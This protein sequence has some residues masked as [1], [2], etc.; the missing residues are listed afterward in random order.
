[1]RCWGSPGWH[2]WMAGSSGVRKRLLPAR[3][4]GGGASPLSPVRSI[5]RI[6]GDHLY[7]HGRHSVAIILKRLA[8]L[9]DPNP[10]VYGGLLVVLTCVVRGRA[11]ALRLLAYATIGA[12]GLE[13]CGKLLF[14]QVR[15][16]RLL[17]QALS[18]YPSGTAMRA[19][20]FAMVVLVIWGPARRRSWPQ[21]WLRR[22]VVGWP[23]LIST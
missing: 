8:R 5:D 19:M 13:L 20:V 15:T 16:S 6:V 11:P 7:Q 22:A 1:M 4:P 12:Y 9:G 2:G 14:P 21:V 10:L 18:P 17:G 3:P 23:I